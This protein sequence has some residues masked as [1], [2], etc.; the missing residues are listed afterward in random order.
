MRNTKLK[1]GFTIVEL[2]VVIAVMAVLSVGAVVAYRGVQAHG[3]RTALTADVNALVE[4]VNRFNQNAWGN[5]SVARNPGLTPT[6]TVAGT[7]TTPPHTITLTADNRIEFVIPP[8][9]IF[10]GETFY[11]RFTSPEARARAINFMDYDAATRRAS[12]ATGRIS[13]WGY[14]AI[15]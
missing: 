7:A 12:A 11:V 14:P 1:K 5:N 3:R 2:I 9:G 8:H 13:N 15:Q 10:N 4:S 6:L